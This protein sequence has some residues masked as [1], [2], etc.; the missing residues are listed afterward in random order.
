MNTE[1]YDAGLK[2]LGSN[3]PSFNFTCEIMITLRA[4]GA[5]IYF[6]NFTP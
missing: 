4:L 2:V 6:L 5:L 3:K 1:N